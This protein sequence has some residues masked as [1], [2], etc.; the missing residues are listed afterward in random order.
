[1]DE[2]FISYLLMCVTSAFNHHESLNTIYSMV[3]LVQG[4]EMS[5]LYSDNIDCTD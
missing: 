4:L 2:E 1:M 5:V 3:S